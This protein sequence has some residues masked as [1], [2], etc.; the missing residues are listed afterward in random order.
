MANTHSHLHNYLEQLYK[1]YNKRCFVSPDPLEFLYRYDRHEDRE[2]VGLI[3]SSLAYGRVKM[4]I[5]NAGRVIESMGESPHAFLVSQTPDDLSR[6]FKGFRHRFTDDKEL[7]S[8][9]VSIRRCI[10]KY[11]SIETCFSLN[12]RKNNQDIVKAAS[13]FVKEMCKMA[14]IEK[15]F[16]LP[17]PKR[18]SAC[19]RLF[20][21]LRWMIRDD[22]VDPGGRT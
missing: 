6:L 5:A 21:Y 9:L 17:D 15:T 20:L 16:L 12:L 11:G 10:E 3:A 22:D 8:L 18:G 2:I 13:G 14:G 19:K 4:I 7:V 1:A